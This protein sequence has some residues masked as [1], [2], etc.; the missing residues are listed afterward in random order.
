MYQRKNDTFLG[1]NHM[2]TAELIELIKSISNTDRIFLLEALNSNAGFFSSEGQILYIVIDEF[3]YASDG[4]DTEYLK[5]QTHVR[6]SSVANNPTF[7]DGF[8]NIIVFKGDLSEED[9]LESFVKLCRVHASNSTELNF[10]D[11][12]YSLISIFQLPAEEK[13]KNAVGLFGELMFM[14]TVYETFGKDLSKFWHLTGPYSKYDFSNGSTSLEIKTTLSEQKEVTIK[15]QQIFGEDTCYLV[16]V[17][18]NRSETGKT[19][20]EVVESLANIPNAFNSINF[21]INLAKELKRV[22]PNDVL[23]SKMVFSGFDVYDS[24]SINPFPVVPDEVSKMTYNLALY[25]YEP[26]SQEQLIKLLENY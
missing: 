24:Y 25:C 7:S 6:I 21:S 16:A 3:N 5:L 10:K 15:H 4:I 18:C 13:L 23:E 12:F 19:I 20:A 2:E 26:Y 9:N 11:F 14:K 8:Y 22:S 17:N 1:G